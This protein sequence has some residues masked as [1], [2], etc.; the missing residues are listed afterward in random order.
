MTRRALII[1][2]LCLAALAQEAQA[3]PTTRVNFTGTAITRTYPL[4]AGQTVEISVGLPSPSK[5]PP[6]GRLAV[7]WAGYRKILHALDPDF[8][9]VYRAPKA[10][11]FELKV[12]AVT[13]E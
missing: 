12:S 13:D 11:A 3:P 8:Y 2:A 7:E 4:T 1:P 6:N 9:M 10:S 5:L